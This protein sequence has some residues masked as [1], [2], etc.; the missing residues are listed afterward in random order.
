MPIKKL[1][2]EQRDLVGRKIHEKAIKAG[3]IGSECYAIS[4]HCIRDILEECT[5]KEFPAMGWGDEE[6]ILDVNFCPDRR[7]L[8]N[9][10]IKLSSNEFKHFTQ[11]CNKI[12]EW[13]EE[14][15]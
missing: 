6:S 9:G 12:V 1:T 15:E 8:I 4:T 5:E 3:M 10:K 7:I 11:R 2:K 14:Q 13:I